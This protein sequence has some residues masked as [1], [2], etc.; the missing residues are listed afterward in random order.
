MNCS[1]IHLR[2]CLSTQ[3]CSTIF[4]RTFIN[5]LESSPVHCLKS[6]P[7]GNRRR[8]AFSG[9]ADT[10]G[11]VSEQHDVKLFGLPSVNLLQNF[12]SFCLSL[13]PYYHLSNPLDQMVLECS[14]DNLMQKI[15]CKEL[16]DVG[17]RK[18][19]CERLEKISVF[20]YPLVLRQH[21][22]I[23]SRRP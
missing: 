18:E 23:S 10:L 11:M 2:D 15:G 12:F 4:F 17:S 7:S 19:A 16:V 20:C 21:T 13:A 14:F 1:N 8:P 9:T 5:A 22:T 6:R 3:Y